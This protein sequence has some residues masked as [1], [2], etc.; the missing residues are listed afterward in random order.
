[1][2]IK[3]GGQLLG[4]DV[5]TGNIIW[6]STGLSFV[7][8]SAKQDNLIYA[9]RVDA[10]IVALYPETGVE[11]GRIEISPNRTIEDDGGYVLHYAIAASDDYLA[12]YYGNSQELI[13]FEK[14]DL[15]QN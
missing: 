1:M 6:R 8:G 9:I 15:G 7:T 12:A 4:I 5:T 2:I 10:A 11:A 13:V 14:V 3:V